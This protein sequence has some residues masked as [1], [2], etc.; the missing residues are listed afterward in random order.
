M[1]WVG[2]ALT[3]DDMI[4]KR[5]VLKTSNGSHFEIEGSGFD[6]SSYENETQYCL[7]PVNITLLQAFCGDS[8]SHS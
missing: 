2:L 1:R 8:G 7:N 5:T 3:F 6:F 4:M